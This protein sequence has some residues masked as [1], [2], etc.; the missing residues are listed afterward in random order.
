MYLSKPPDRTM[1]RPICSLPDT[2]IHG[3]DIG[4]SI[5][6]PSATVHTQL[7]SPAWN[8]R[9]LFL[10]IGTISVPYTLLYPPFVPKPSRGDTYLDTLDSRSPPAFAFLLGKDWKRSVFAKPSRS[11][12]A[13]KFAFVF[14][15]RLRQKKTY[16]ISTLN[17]RDCHDI[18]DR[19]LIG[20]Q[21]TSGGG[22]RKLAFGPFSQQSIC[23]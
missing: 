11:T 1:P 8:C 7:P 13:S 10:L 18:F 17:A 15:Y 22:W 16:L 12:V 9:F 6:R 19:S 4:V 20:F 21:N 14:H 5:F 2:T 23:Y 3:L